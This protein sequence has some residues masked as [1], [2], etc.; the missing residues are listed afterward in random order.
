[1]GTYHD[2][3]DQI[4]DP[5]ALLNLHFIHFPPSNVL[6]P[7]HARKSIGAHVFPNNQYRNV[8]LSLLQPRNARKDDGIDGGKYVVPSDVSGRDGKGWG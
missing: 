6:P 3:P 8:S 4:P 1:M 5:E 2:P 7:H